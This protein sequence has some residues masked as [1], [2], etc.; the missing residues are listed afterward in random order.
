[1]LSQHEGGALK[2]QHTNPLILTL[3]FRFLGPN[4]CD[5]DAKVKETSSRGRGE[6]APPQQ[7]QQGQENGEQ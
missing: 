7:T 6:S 1:M 2:V 4:G 3:S 5:D